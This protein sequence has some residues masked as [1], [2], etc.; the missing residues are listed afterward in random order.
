MPRLPEINKAADNTTAFDMT[1]LHD[2]CRNVVLI[3][4]HFTLDRDANH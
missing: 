3:L 4:I 2:E 1:D